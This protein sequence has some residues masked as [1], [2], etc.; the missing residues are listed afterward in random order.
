MNRKILETGQK[1]KFIA[2]L[3]HTDEPC[4]HN[5]W[6][7]IFKFSKILKLDSIILSADRVTMSFC[8]NFEDDSI[9]KL[10]LSEIQS[11]HFESVTGFYNY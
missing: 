1:G 9:V 5:T 2:S 7:N 10:F 8:V 3:I 4:V 11:I 6:S